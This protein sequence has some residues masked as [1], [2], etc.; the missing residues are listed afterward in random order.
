MARPICAWVRQ[1]LFTA[2]RRVTSWKSFRGNRIRSKSEAIRRLVQI[3][4]AFDEKADDLHT[5]LIAMSSDMGP[6]AEQ[7]LEIAELPS[8]SD[9]Q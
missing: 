7:M 2:S 6:R 4:L 8:E 1:G 9:P 5:A 3:G